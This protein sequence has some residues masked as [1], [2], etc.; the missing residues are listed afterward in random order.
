MAKSF[1]VGI[2]AQQGIDVS[3]GNVT[4]SAGYLDLTKHELRNAQIQNLASD[5]ST[6]VVGQIYYN[7]TSNDLK[8]YD[9]TAW[10]VISVG[11]DLTFGSPATLAIGS[12]TS[13]GVSNSAAR[14]DHVHAMPT[15][16]TSASTQAVGDSAA[17]GS[18]STISRSDHKHAMPAF[19]SVTA[20]TTFGASSANGTSTD[21]A[22]ADHSHGTP[23]LTND[24]PT[25]Q[26]VGDTAVV[27]TAVSPARADHKH[28]MPSFGNVTSQTSFGGSSGNGSSSS[29]ARADHTHG[30]P[31]HDAAA[32]SA[33]KLSDLAAAAADI[34]AGGYKI[35]NVATPVN[36]TDA[37]NKGY[38]DTAV[39]GL[40]WKAAVNLLA[41]SNVA[42]T[43]ATNTLVID[44][45]AALDQTD[46]GL[47][48][49]LLT[50]QTTDTEE[51]I[52][53]YTDNGTTYTLTRAADAD[54]Y[55]ELIG[56]SV[57][58]MEGTT[59]GSTSWVQSDHYITSFAGQDWVQFSGT[60]TY[61]ASNGVQLVGSNFSGVV[62]SNGG[63]T[64]GSSGFQI[65]TAIVVRKYSA[66]IGDGSA[67][68]Y[69]VTHG[70]GTRDVTVAIYDNNSPYA[71]VIAD[72]E[73]A[74]TNTVTVKFGAAPA[75]N[76]YRVVI[77]G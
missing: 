42:L 74:T 61:T 71:E 68:S 30:T 39:A 40:N 5:P 31:A 50:N 69:T 32:H 62:V 15:F 38:V 41:N 34:S 9:G 24:T 66:S 76:R 16:G 29:I 77:H 57:F 27:G 64:V 67:T 75:S 49:I 10:N 26:A 53:L 36:A 12:T 28:A 70:L 33:I 6:P 46:S 58:V 23:A 51:G 2:D 37:A 52:Y 65:D 35:T 13:D 11:T 4:V 73:H 14:A 21:I 60:G 56:A 19:G 44:G 3:G 7:T 25:T 18:A 63:L 59:Y 20:V 43:G 22:R 1:L 72:V 54:S 55:S 48:R 17:G 8:F 47:Y 45:H